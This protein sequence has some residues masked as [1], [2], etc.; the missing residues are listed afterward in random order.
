MVIDEA[1]IITSFRPG[2]PG[3]RHWSFDADAVLTRTAP[4]S[5][6]PVDCPEVKRNPGSGQHESALSCG[7][8]PAGLGDRSTAP[9]AVPE[10][11]SRLVGEKDLITH[12][13]YT[14]T[15]Q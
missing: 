13:A 7:S 15:R 2:Q 14:A 6:P 10:S 5:A 3:L 4:P 11:L 1:D 8:L 9:L 12:H